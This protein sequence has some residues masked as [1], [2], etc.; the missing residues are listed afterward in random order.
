MSTLSTMASDTLLA[1]LALLLAALA[2][3]FAWQER[4]WRA[5]DAVVYSVEDSIRYVTAH[6]APE[7]AQI[8]RPSDVRRILE[9]EVRY[10][11]N[12][13]VRNG[14]GP[15]VAG[16]LSAAEFAQESLARLGHAY[17]GPHIIEV[18]DLRAEYLGTIGAVGEPLTAAEVAD[19]EAR[20]R[21]TPHSNGGPG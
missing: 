17:D 1:L 5:E 21:T 18:L 6:L 14:S 2:A 9:W 15:V 13:G 7:T 8:I 11:Q 3:G 16:G 20:D 19:L 12:P 4:W 10:L